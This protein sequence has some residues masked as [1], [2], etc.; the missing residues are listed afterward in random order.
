M[1]SLPGLMQ[2]ALAVLV[3]AAATYDI[4]Y[5][6]IPNW[7]VLIG[8]I[9][10]FSMRTV[11]FHADGLKTS[12]LGAALALAIYLPLFALRAMGAGDLKLMVAIGAFTGPSSWIV[13]FVITAILGGLLA[14]ALL[15]FRG[16]LGRTL[17]NVLFILGEL[18]HLRPPYR[19]RPE[20]DVTHAGAVRLPHGVSIA[21]G[22]LLFLAF[23]HLRS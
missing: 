7:L 17:R 10:G 22:A 23:N 6:R 19:T 5:R 13:V 1:D 11:F 4:R 9:A 2:T 12:L 14:V 15:L 18:L 21:G 16:Q 3:L 20:L 8:L